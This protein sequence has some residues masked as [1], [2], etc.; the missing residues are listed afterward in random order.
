VW[1]GGWGGIGVFLAILVGF[2]LLLRTVVVGKARNRDA[3]VAAGQPSGERP[4]GQAGYTGRFG[5]S[6]PGRV[7]P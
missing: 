6:A 7:G 4:T 3:A 1:G 2:G 5:P